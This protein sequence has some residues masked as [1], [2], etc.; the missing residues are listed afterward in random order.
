M[1]RARRFAAI[2]A[3]LLVTVVATSDELVFNTVALSNTSVPEGNG[4]Y[5][6]PSHAVA[7]NLGQIAFNSAVQNTSNPPN[8][9]AGMY[10]YEH[11]VVRNVA[12]EPSPAPD[13]NG[14]LR[15]IAQKGQLF[16]VDSGTG[17]DLRIISNLSLVGVLQGSEG[18]I[19]K[20]LNDHG[21]LAFYARFTDGTDGIFSVVIPEPSALV[22]LTIGAL[23]AARRR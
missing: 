11:G 14:V 18:L 5:W 3:T 10:L 22:L 8:D 9:D 7:N 16:D 13:G 2:S 19:G 23:L 20:A 12:R 15:L 4:E 1:Y 6:S 17:E 21:L